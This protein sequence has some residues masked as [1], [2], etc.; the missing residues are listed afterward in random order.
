L[1]QND[2]DA[3]QAAVPDV[4]VDTELLRDKDSEG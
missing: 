1:W 4:A 2:I 3:I